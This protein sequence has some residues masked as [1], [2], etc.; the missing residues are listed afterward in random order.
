MERYWNN[1]P[2]TL[3]LAMLSTSTSN[4]LTKR[5]KKS[6]H[7]AKYDKMCQ[8]SIANAQGMQDWQAELRKYHEYIAVLNIKKDCNL[9][10]FW[11]V[12]NEA[13]LFSVISL[14]IFPSEHQSSIPNLVMHRSQCPSC[15]S[16]ICILRVLVLIQ[17]AD[18]HR[19][20]VSSWI[21]SL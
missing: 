19:L 12:C 11:Q 18:S 9:M 4:T 6:L 5:N 10:N 8:E 2:A 14:I 3:T 7:L 1:C 17:Q 20:M 13:C 21:R 16:L 15:P